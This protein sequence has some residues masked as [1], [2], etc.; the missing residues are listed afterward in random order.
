M[1]ISDAWTNLPAFTVGEEL[2]SAVLNQV[3]GN[4]QWLKDPSKYWAR[5]KLTG[6]PPAVQPNTDTLCPLNTVNS[7]EDPSGMFNPSTHLF[8]IQVNG[9]YIVTGAF[10]VPAA[11]TPYAPIAVSLYKNATSGLPQIAGSNAQATGNVITRVLLLSAGDTL[12]L[13]VW[14]NASVALNYDLGFGGTGNSMSVACL[15]RQ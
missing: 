8:T 7:G 11:G 9:V 15:Y 6:S 12:G 1:S 10:R 13:D 4:F 5:A 2:P 3:L 14:H